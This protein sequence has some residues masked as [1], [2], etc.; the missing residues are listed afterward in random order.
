LKET[1]TR[2]TNAVLLYCLIQIMTGLAHAAPCDPVTEVQVQAAEDARY[3]APTS[4]DYAAL[5]R[6]RADDLIYIHSSA[7]VGNKQSCID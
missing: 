6:L 2:H 3:A 5:E 4:L 1:V 7:V